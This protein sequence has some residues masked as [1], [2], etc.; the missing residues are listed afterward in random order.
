[1][2]CLVTGG[3]GFLGQHIVRLLRERGDQ[4]VVLARKEYSEINALGA[5]SVKCDIRDKK[6]LEPHFV[7]VDEVYHVAAIADIW[8][9]PNTFFSINVLGTRNII[10][11]CRKNRV[12]KLIYTS[13]PSVVFAGKP[14]RRVD[15]NE[16]YPSRYLAEYPRTK[17]LAEKE[18]LDAN[19]AGLFT[20][21]LRPHLI[22]GPGD[23]HLI[24]RVIERARKGQLAQV[25]DGQNVVDIIY[26]ENAARAHLQAAERLGPKGTCNGKAYFLSQNEPVK[27]WAFISEILRRAKAPQ[28]KKKIPF[29]VAY[30]LGFGME[31]FYRLLGKTTEPRMTRFLACQLALDHH[32]DTSRAR[33]DF[34]YD[35]TV[36][37]EE[38][39]NRLF[40]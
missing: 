22:W 13:S 6:S 7:D 20:V 2:K 35:A 37:T 19:E 26:V 31:V 16:P 27:L 9:D 23:R 34:E 1:M 21:S 39:L 40:S 4:V 28:V 24:P 30:L 29:W 33:N 10:E 12:P 18:V 25:G 5:H 14:Q 17:S 32:Y 8:G 15:E 11:A 38:G 36:S 3:G